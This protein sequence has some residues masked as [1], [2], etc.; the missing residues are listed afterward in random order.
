MHYSEKEMQYLI[1]KYP[2]EFFKFPI[3]IIGTEVTLPKNENKK[4]SRID[5]FAKNDKGFIIIELKVN[6]F[7]Q[8]ALGQLMRYADNVKKSWGKID[9]LIGISTSGSDL[10]TDKTFEYIAITNEQLEKVQKKYK[11]NFNNVLTNSESL[12][13]DSL[14]YVLKNASV[15][16]LNTLFSQSKKLVKWEKI[17]RT[18]Y[19]ADFIKKPIKIKSKFEMVTAQNRGV[20]IVAQNREKSFEFELK[21]RTNLAKNQL[22]KYKRDDSEQELFLVSNILRQ[23]YEQLTEAAAYHLSWDEIYDTVKQFKS[24]PAEIIDNLSRYRYHFYQKVLDIIYEEVLSELHKQGKIEYKKMRKPVQSK[25]KEY[26]FYFIK[27]DRD[28][29]Q[30]NDVFAF[31]FGFYADTCDRFTVRVINPDDYFEQYPKMAEYYKNF[32]LKE[33]LNLSGR[34]IGKHP[35]Y[36]IDISHIKTF[37]DINSKEI[38]RFAKHITKVI[39]KYCSL[40]DEVL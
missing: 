37:E 21:V 33:H 32:L 38:K 24:I 15:K 4:I 6:K 25:D 16:E 20:D 2:Y 30:L 18:N 14:I 40:L 19:K 9:K 27:I 26:Y 23:Y 31:S 39:D 7:N 10:L 5:I 29:G 35:F 17:S 8:K 34:E 12:A 1:A 13:Q 28:F 36:S 22:L 3:E 11:V